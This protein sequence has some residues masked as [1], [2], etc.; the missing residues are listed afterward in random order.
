MNKYLGAAFIF[1]CLILPHTVSA[2]T[3]TAV[4]LPTNFSPSTMNDDGVAVGTV[5]LTAIGTWR[6][7][8]SAAVAKC[9][10][11]STLNRNPFP[12]VILGNGSIYSSHSDMQQNKRTYECTS[13]GQFNVLPL[14]VG[15]NQ[16]T[17]VT[18]IN[19]QRFKAPIA[20]TTNIYNPSNS[21]FGI[22]LPGNASWMSQGLAFASNEKGLI[23][24][25]SQK[26]IPI[27][28]Y[29]QD[30]MTSFTSLEQDLGR[31]YTISLSDLNNEGTAAINVTRNNRTEAL[32]ATPESILYRYSGGSKNESVVI[33]T[34]LKD[35]D[36]IGAGYKYTGTLPSEGVLFQNGTILNLNNSGVISNSAVAIPSTM[37]IRE[38]MKVIK[39]AQGKLQL[40][41]RVYGASAPTPGGRYYL[42]NENGNQGAGEY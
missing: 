18:L 3:F 20:N 25:M 10:T 41:V 24:S 8:D 5:S 15:A 42:L 39:N 12:A 22:P 9:S 32:V 21:S 40:L 17:N 23:L 29:L 6:V 34:L 35:E 13:A 28:S 7:G 26:G 16:Y 19:N 1:S 14:P 37:K 4:R 2:Q 38:V 31:G 27:I 36:S 30:Q 11:L 33:S